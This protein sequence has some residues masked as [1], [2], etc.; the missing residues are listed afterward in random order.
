MLKLAELKNDALT[1]RENVPILAANPMEGYTLNWIVPDHVISGLFNGLLTI[2]FVQLPDNDAV[3]K[4]EISL[5]YSLSEFWFQNQTVLFKRK[6]K[7]LVTVLSMPMLYC[8]PS[9]LPITLRVLGLFERHPAKKMLVHL[10]NLTSLPFWWPS[11]EVDGRIAWQFVHGYGMK[12]YHR[13]LQ[14]H[15][16]N[17]V[18]SVNSFNKSY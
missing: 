9:V 5:R 12:V 11:L 17:F 4:L 1:E 15:V 6:G 14:L 2:I 16:S 13:A 7:K 10:N 3:D 8:M 18:K